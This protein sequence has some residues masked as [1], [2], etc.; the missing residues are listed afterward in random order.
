MFG[1]GN[2]LGGVQFS[3]NGMGGM[4]GGQRVHI[5]RNGVPVNIAQK[6]DSLNLSIEI[7]RLYRFKSLRCKYPISLILKF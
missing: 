6:P 2:P 7:P 3:V 1:N 5:F 4:G